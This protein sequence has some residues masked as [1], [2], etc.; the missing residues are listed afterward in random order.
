MDNNKKVLIAVSAF[1]EPFYND[2]KK[3]GAHVEEV[4]HPFQV[5]TANNF[6]VDLASESGSFG[7]DEHSVSKDA[8]KGDDLEYFRKNEDF[9]Q[10]CKSISRAGELD[11]NAYDVIYFAGGHGC[12]FDFPNGKEL[13]ALAGQIYNNNGIVAA[14]CHGPEIFDNLIDPETNEPLIKGK[15]ITGFTDEGEVEIGVDN[16]MKQKLLK[17]VKQIAEEKGATYKHPSGNW[18]DYVV[19]S[20]RVLTGVNPQSAASLAKKAVTELNH[21]RQDIRNAK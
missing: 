7:W 16:V 4:M 1:H 9:N 13:Q 20:Q 18:D 3:T 6:D 11:P 12:C 8:L 2:G 5:F 19:S 14:V 10:A 21:I 15:E 17:T